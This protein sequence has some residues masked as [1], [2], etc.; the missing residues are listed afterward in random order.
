MNPDFD[1]YQMLTR[2]VAM[3][4]GT[5]L[6][7][8]LVYYALGVGGEAGEVVDEV[9]KVAFH[10]H[11]LNKEK[12]IEELG[13]VLWY[14]A[15]MADSLAVPLSE[16]AGKNMDKL[17]KRYPDGFSVERSKKRIR[18]EREVVPH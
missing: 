11:E 9:K 8:A 10:G 5:A 4:F 16:V 13:D 2:K 14:V 6:Q 12:L 3:K 18:V 1:E 7:E 15:R 17:E